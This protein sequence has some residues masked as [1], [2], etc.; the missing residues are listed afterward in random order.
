MTV[1]AVSERRLQW[2][3]RAIVGILAWG[4]TVLTLSLAAPHTAL[5]RTAIVTGT[6]WVFI[7]RGPGNQFPPFARIPSGST[8]EVQEVRADW[9]Q[10]ITASGQVGFIHVRF[11][12]FPDEPT[13]Q[14][15]PSP[16]RSTFPG[17][18]HSPVATATPQGLPGFTVTAPSAPSPT[19]GRSPT[20][21]R[22][23]RATRTLP[24]TGTRTPTRSHTPTR[25]P[26][27]T[28]SF[29]PARTPSPTPPRETTPPVGSAA[30]FGRATPLTVTPSRPDEATQRLHEIEAELLATRQELERCRQ[31]TP[32]PSLAS[33]PQELREELI[34]LRSAI[35]RKAP[36]D[37]APNPFGETASGAPGPANS[38]V[39]DHVVTPLA[40]FLG[41]VGLAIGWL[42]G[43]RYGRR[44][45]RMRRWRLQVK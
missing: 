39:D 24:P 6:E 27:P 22:T 30:P 36:A 14:G 18:A 33:C 7:R 12:S 45:E 41:L 40:V 37:K 29:S 9:A 38:S 13:N 16:S 35:E 17:A 10:I 15:L 42:S 25:S 2:I 31:Q 21:T 20:S 11:L 19:L 43:T 32:G 28:R 1:N 4:M 23:P 8:V 34:R 3:Q 44:T 5:G 26:T